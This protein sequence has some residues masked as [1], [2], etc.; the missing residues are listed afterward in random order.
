MQHKPI[1]VI[2]LALTLGALAGPCG[3]HGYDAE[4]NTWCPHPGF[5]PPDLRTCLEICEQVGST[6]GLAEECDGLAYG[7]NGSQCELGDGK[8][9]VPFEVGCNDPLP[10]GYAGYH[11]CCSQ[12][13]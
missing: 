10:E 2:M 9:G 11:C 5:D 8:S 6:C 4:W 7:L 3:E 1:L 13:Y 12:A